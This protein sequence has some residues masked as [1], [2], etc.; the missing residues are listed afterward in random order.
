[1]ENVT[2]PG[3]QTSFN[4]PQW[5]FNGEFIRY[6]T[7]RDIDF[8]GDQDLLALDYTG[9]QI[10][11]FRNGSSEEGFLAGAGGDE[12][13]DRTPRPRPAPRS[14]RKLSGPELL[15]R[16]AEMDATTVRELAG[17]DHSTEE[18]GGR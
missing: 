5:F 4:D 16:L 13:T 6:V 7:A 12:A 18:E 17:S 8:D 1:M 11:L 14:L 15:Q 9:D 10:L 2:E 3:G